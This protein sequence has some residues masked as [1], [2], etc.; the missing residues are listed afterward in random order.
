MKSGVR[1]TCHCRKLA[2]ELDETA[3]QTA[4]MV[5]GITDAL[6]ILADASISSAEAKARSATADDRHR[7][8][9]SGS[10]RAA[11]PEH[12]AG[13][14]PVCPASA[15][16]PPTVVYDEIWSSLVLDELRVPALSGVAA[17][18]LSMATSTFLGRPACTGCHPENGTRALQRPVIFSTDSSGL[19]YRAWR[20]S[21]RRADRSDPTMRLSWVTMPL[22]S[23]VSTR[24]A[25]GH[26][27]DVVAR[28]R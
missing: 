7:P 5:E 24:I 11:L 18:N 20:R 25:F 1:S 17:S 8:A 3:R 19:D 15:R 26:I 10:H 16:L 21:P 14:P 9:G 6:E 22:S 28:R 2:R 27:V 23:S 12:G 13:R 4:S